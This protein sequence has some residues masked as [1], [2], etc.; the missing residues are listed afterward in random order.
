LDKKNTD[1][2]LILFG[3]TG[4]NL[5]KQA[6]LSQFKLQIIYVGIRHAYLNAQNSCFPDSRIGI[7][8]QLQSLS[9]ISF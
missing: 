5:T 9:S 8:Q 4:I 7:T 1:L 2:H 3:V 6:V